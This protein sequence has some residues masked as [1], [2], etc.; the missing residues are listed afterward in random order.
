MNIEKLETIYEI[1]EDTKKYRPGEWGVLRSK[2]LKENNIS[3]AF[4]WAFEFKQSNNLELIDIA[5]WLCFTNLDS[6]IENIKRFGIKEFT[7][8]Y[9]FEKNDYGRK[10][11]E[12]IVDLGCRAVGRVKIKKYDREVY[13]TKFKVGE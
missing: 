6:V 1:L 10:K 3:V 7:V 12:E 9:D 2:T 13:A 5:N 4:W 11:F 8:A